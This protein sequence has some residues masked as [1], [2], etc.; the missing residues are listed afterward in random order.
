MK[1]ITDIQV[2]NKCYHCGDA[3]SSSD[4]VSFD[5]KNFC[6]RGCKTVYE[7]LNQ[8]DLC[9]YYNIDAN[10][11]INPKIKSSEKF[12]YLD[13]K[14]I[15]TKLLD[16]K[17]NN[18][19]RIQF[20]LPQ[21]HCASCVW[22]LEKLYKLNKG[23]N[24]S[25]IN[26]PKK[27]L[28]VS[29]ELD[30][31]SLKELVILLASLGYEPALS[32]ADTKKKTN[33]FHNRKL[34]Y[35]IGVA[36]F[37]FGNIMLFSMPEYFDFTGDLSRNFKDYFAYIN[38]L[39][40]IPVLFYS[41]LDYFKSALGGLKRKII[42]LDFPLSLGM[43]TLFLTSSYEII[44]AQGPGYLDSFTGLIF[45]LLLGKAFQQ[46]TFQNI[47]FERDYKSYFPLYANLIK[48]NAHTS[49]PLEKLKK[50]DRILVRN[51]DLIPADGILLKGTAYIDYSFVTGESTPVYKELGEI[52]YA[53]GKQE[54]ASLEIEIIKEVSNSYLTEL[55][56]KQNFKKEKITG[57]KTLADSIGKWFTIFVLSTAVIAGIFWLPDLGQSIKIFAAVLIIAC[58]CALALTI[59]YTY[60]NTIR[61]L[62]NAGFYLKNSDVVEQLAQSN[63]LVFDKTGTLTETNNIEIEFIGDNLSEKELAY[64]KS[65]CALSNHPASRKLNEILE[66]EILPI[67]EFREEIGQGIEGKI[68]G[69]NI[70]IGSPEYLDLPENPGVH[71]SIDGK[72]K[73]RYV[74]HNKLRKASLTQ[75]PELAKDYQMAL[76]SG[77]TNK[78]EKLL[79]EL[80]PENSDLLFNQKPID[81]LNF[82]TKLSKSGK[83]VIMIGD[84]LNDA[85]ALKSSHVGISMTDNTGHFSPAS[86]VIMDSLSFDKLRKVLKFSKFS[87][88]TVIVGFI[89][90]AAYN[91]TGLYFAI[92]GL[93]TPV[94]AAILMPLSSI[95]VVV[96]STVTTNVMAKKLSIK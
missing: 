46:K 37:C 7:I 19:A 59:P 47:S 88:N 45:F 40:A 13:D 74:F 81:K 10:P 82:I 70:K 44:S 92:Q 2:K 63:F 24:Q 32:L 58:P 68:N 60:G 57:L 9:T 95:T 84:G 71:I 51:Q 31:I 52:I 4:A 41:D 49:I 42:N 18:Q 53:G 21:I 14:E 3:C 16:F 79:S 23:I 66:S 65:L 38:L 30:K 28:S 12:D 89:L 5:D 43:I 11:G 36:G 61:I 6:C 85:G 83:K 72:Y 86:D 75:L 64:T 34:Y 55:W 27:T 26:F 54:G 80:L 78:D 90:S 1:P 93:L 33:S 96:F 76:C 17:N 77:D 35:Q 29:F 69:Q 8:N 62:G 87:V 15:I 25:S 67:M 73:G 20:F 91:I 22:L 56:N 39:F 94:F 50:G 48:N